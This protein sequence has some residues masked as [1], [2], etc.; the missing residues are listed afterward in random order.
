MEK[1]KFK[2]SFDQV[3][4]YK[5]I[6]EAIGNKPSVY[7]TTGIPFWD[8]EH[9]S[10]SMLAAHLDPDVDSASRKHEFM[11]K[12]VDWIAS[13]LGKEN[14][15][16]LDLGC[17]PGLYAKRFADKGFSVTGVDFSK[18]SIA[19]ARDNFGY[20]RN[21]FIYQDYLTINYE[22]EYN[23]AILIYFDFGVL[24]PE[25][26]VVL[27]KKIY[28]SL[29]WGGLFVVDAC[30]PNHYK[31]FV[32]SMTLE[33]QEGGFWRPNPYINIKRTASYPNQ[34]YLEQYTI[35][36]AEDVATYNI[37]NHGFEPEEFKKAMLDAGFSS[38]NLYEDAKGTELA[39]ESPT[40]CAVCK[41]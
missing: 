6:I 18:R 29:K 40:L 39:D 36:T 28:S 21:E 7:E 5:K 27:L 23:L 14:G 13:L 34:N 41:K 16:I 30:T 38:V 4:P 11:D 31:K 2:I 10:K 3:S 32:D 12:S 25:N 17:G 1:D 37:W 9:I 15:K 24:S 19:Y 8:D 26:R 33:Y 35:I 22:N 20:E